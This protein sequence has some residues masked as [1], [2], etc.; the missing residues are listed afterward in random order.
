MRRRILEA[1]IILA[2]LQ[3]CSW[4]TGI[5]MRCDGSCEVEMKRIIIIEKE[6]E[7]GP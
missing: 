3:G 5:L 2:A 6:R 7:H 4:D 1:I